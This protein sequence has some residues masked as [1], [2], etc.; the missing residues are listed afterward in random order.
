MAFILK[1]WK[2]EYEKIL[3]GFYK[4]NDKSCI[5]LSL[6]LNMDRATIY[7]KR[8]KAVKYIKRQLEFTI[9]KKY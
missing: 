5:K 2:Q 4:K 3:E 8:D 7:R 1:G 9:N 6:E